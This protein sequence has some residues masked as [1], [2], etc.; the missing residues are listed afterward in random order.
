MG[1]A[2]NAGD[3]VEFMVKDQFFPRSIRYSLQALD[4]NLAKLPRA[5]AA[6]KSVTRLRNKTRRADADK[7]VKKG[8]HDYLDR[9]QVDL[10]GI[11]ETLQRTWF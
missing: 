2:V 5:E 11:H 8:L 1:P 10:I 9:I 4:Y 6:R 3:V 7:L